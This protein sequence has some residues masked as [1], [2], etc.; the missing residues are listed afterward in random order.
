[1]DQ[2]KVIPIT[3]S[4]RYNQVETRLLA[5]WTVSRV[6]RLTTEEI[7]RPVAIQN[8][9]T[10]RLATEKSLTTHQFRIRMEEEILEGLVIIR[11]R[12]YLTSIYHKKLSKTDKIPLWILVTNNRRFITK[13]RSLISR[14]R[15][16]LSMEEK[17]WATDYFRSI[18]PKDSLPLINIRTKPGNRHLAKTILC[19]R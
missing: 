12:G 6:N 18:R 15:I 4:N 16:T 17:A 3:K 1:M 14:L 19:F 2:G 5:P 10:L 13:I 11:I 9:I 8:L 7:I